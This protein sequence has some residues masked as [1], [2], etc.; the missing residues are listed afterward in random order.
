MPPKRAKVEHIP[1]A[2][3]RMEVGNN[4]AVYKKTMAK[5]AEEPNLPIKE[6]VRVRL[7]SVMEP[8]RMQERPQ[9]T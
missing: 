2:E 9:R 6:K 7:G 5:A 3:F 1:T 8:A 4:S